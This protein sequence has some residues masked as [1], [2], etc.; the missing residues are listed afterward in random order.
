MNR[1]NFGFFVILL[2]V[3]T[4]PVVYGQISVGEYAIQRSVE[5]VID[6]AG[7]VHVKHTLA[8][9]GTPKQIE[10]IK[11][12]VSNVMVTDENGQEQLFSMLGEYGV[13]V[14]P[15]NEEILVEYDLED[16]L[17]QKNGVWTWDFRYLKTTSFIFPEEV[18]LIFSNGKPVYLDDKKGIA[19]HGCQMILEYSVDE[20][21]SFKNV[22]W[23]DREFIVEIRSHAGI[24]EFVFD[25]PTKS[26]A[27]DV[28]E[29]DRFVTTIVPLELLWGPYEV[30]LEDERILAYDYINNGTHVWLVMKPDIQGEISIIGTTVVPEFSIIAP[31]AIGFL[32]IIILPM[33]RKINLH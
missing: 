29:E 26:I 14:M 1:K 32:M 17:Y 9:T 12:V 27:F 25:Q 11:G 33:I 15:S 18:D 5:I 21:T 16:S 28:T 20:P 19:C 2:L 30:F 24:D 13:L 22:V 23:E 7:S 10:L 3:S 6:S 4:I 8:P 31:L